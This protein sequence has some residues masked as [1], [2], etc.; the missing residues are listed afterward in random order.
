VKDDQLRYVAV[1]EAFAGSAGF[2]SDK[3]LGKR[4]ADL[5]PPD[6][7]GRHEEQDRQVLDTGR[8]LRVTEERTA[9][10]GSPIRLEILR[11]PVLDDASRTI[12]TTGI[13]QDVSARHDLELRLFQSQKLEAVGQ[14]AGGIA[15]DFNNLL[16]VIDGYSEMLL[17]Q[18]EIEDPR[19]SHAEEI[20]RAG[21]RAADLTR[22][23]LAYSRKQVLDPRPFDLNELIGGLGR[24]LHRLIGENIEFTMTSDPALWPV[25][26]DPGQIQQV[27]INLVVN[28]RDAMPR[29]GKLT[30][31]TRN[32]R[33]EEDQ[34]VEDFNV[35]AGEYVMLAVSDTGVGMTP[36][37]RARIFEP[38]FTTKAL[39]QG[40]GLGL[41]TVYGIV[42][43]SGGY[44][45]V[46]SEPGVGTA[47]KV[48]LP[49]SAHVAASEYDLEWSGPARGSE[50]ILLVEDEPAVQAVV[51]KILKRYGYKALVASN[52][53]LALQVCKEHP[54]R[55]DLLLSDVVLPQMSG[56]ELAD[57]VTKRRPGIR[58][59]YISG[60]TDDAIVRHGILEPGTAFL[61][62]PFTPHA[63][64]RKIRDVLDAPGSEFTLAD[65]APRK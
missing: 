8:P 19:R 39:G 20:R 32:V 47:F 15:H 4:E 52:P 63:L 62:K 18:L 14:L 29:G 6:I 5:F 49:R 50:T 26:A 38:F 22:Q 48:F 51:L 42:K 54:E 17:S 57:V 23:L 43:Q 16:T 21:A 11:R 9:P 13:A 12:G 44:V 3:I 45:W 60:Y 64:A 41:S 40:T 10:D 34:N 1:N 61:Q 2:A 53:D 35:S 31:E 46:Y 7:A 33:I 25:L 55:I 65:S 59:L 58:V 28:S 30:I 56:R 27:I 37:V 24:M 36:E